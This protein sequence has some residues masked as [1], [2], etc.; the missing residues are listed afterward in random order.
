[1]QDNTSFHRIFGYLGGDIDEQTFLWRGMIMRVRRIGKDDMQERRVVRFGGCETGEVLLAMLSEEGI[2]V[3]V[4]VWQCNAA[5]SGHQTTGD[6][7]GLKHITLQCF[8][9][10]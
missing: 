9:V 2:V 10:R 8:T 5:T 4:L 1:M 3:A 7:T 6:K